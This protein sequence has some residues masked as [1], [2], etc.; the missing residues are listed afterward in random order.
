MSRVF[1]EHHRRRV[2]SLNGLWDFTFLGNVTTRDVKPAEL[3]FDDRMA[4]PGCFDTTP[5]YAGQR[6]LT[7]YQRTLRLTD[8]ARHRLRFEGSHHITTAH[9]IDRQRGTSRQLGQQ[10]GGFVRFHFD[11]QDL[12][13][14]EYDLVVLVDNRIDPARCPLHQAYM[15]WYHHGGI[16]RDVE[17]HRVGDLW[18]ESLA[19]NTL[20]V[21]A[22]KFSLA[23]EWAADREPGQVPLTISCDGRPLESGNIQL[24]G[25][26]GRIDR[27]FTLPGAKVWSPESPTLHDLHVELGPDDLCD[28]FGLRTIEVRGKD[29]LLNGQPLQLRGVNRHEMHPQFG[30]AQ[31]LDLLVQDV[32][33]IK[34]MGCNFV[35][36]SHYP[37]D[38]RFL[39]LCDQAGLLVWQEAIG[40]QHKAEHLTNEYFLSLQ[41]QQIRAM[42]GAT[43][44]HPSVILWGILNES[45]SHIPA[46]R[47]AYERL[48]GLIRRLD[49]TRP[50]TYACN[51]PQDDLC[52]DLCDVVSIN[53]YPGWYWRE[54]ENIPQEL[55]AIVGFMRD[56]KVGDRPLIISEI[57]AEALAGFRDWNADRWSEPYQ[58]RLLETVIHHILSHPKDYAG[59]AIWLYN[60]FRSSEH[61]SRI[62]NRAR[63][64]NNKGLVDEY[65]RPKMSYD[66]VKRLFT[67]S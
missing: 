9:L 53:T 26:S 23:L 57:G 2:E 35:R 30:H 1:P 44:N 36:G 18:I 62:M 37:Q 15:D 10:I 50:V 32:Q 58:A 42:I 29:L 45:E 54:I 63:G 31:P 22:G 67:Q 33:I 21:T 24:T 38:P 59:L 55:D 49:P 65:R 66:V 14:G 6:G 61:V 5:R 41:E 60:D 43:Q 40:W 39:D 4:V 27:Q 46:S 48:L 7:A 16:T 17:L 47:P 25:K 12:P 28:R 11:L 13:A 20:D 19:I 64:F 34:D 52:L 56:R 51:H 3:R 8:G